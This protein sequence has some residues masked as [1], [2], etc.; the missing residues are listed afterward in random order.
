MFVV[1]T[2][3]AVIR[4][5]LSWRSSTCSW[6]G[7]REPRPSATASRGM[8]SRTCSGRP[9]ATGACAHCRRDRAV[10]PDHTG[11]RRS[12]GAIG[13]ERTRPLPPIFAECCG[14]ITPG[15]RGGIICKGTRLRAAIWLI[16]IPADFHRHCSRCFHPE[17]TLLRVP[18]NLPSLANSRCAAGNSFGGGTHDD[19]RRPET[20][21]R[22]GDHCCEWY[23][24]RRVVSLHTPIVRHL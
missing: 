2:G 21:A 1:R 17:H 19:L 16:P 3:I 9:D 4:S 15:D 6:R 7:M 23:I 5:A 8:S 22:E 12:W 14:D 18:T 10:R 13:G 24:E 11:A 20:P